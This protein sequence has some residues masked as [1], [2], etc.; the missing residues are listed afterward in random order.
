MEAVKPV[1]APVQPATPAPVTPER[2][3]EP[4]QFARSNRPQ[5]QHP[6]SLRPQQPQTPRV[7]SRP[8]DIS[9]LPAFLLRPVKLPKAPEKE[10]KPETAKA[11]KPAKAE[12]P[13]KAPRAPRKKKAAVADPATETTVVKEPDAV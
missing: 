13:A 5:Q 4:A 6:R 11:A 7:E 9:Q 12:K 3:P 10:E 1:E 2:R 8:V